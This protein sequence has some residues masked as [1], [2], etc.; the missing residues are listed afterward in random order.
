MAKEVECVNDDADNELQS[1]NTDMKT[2][3]AAWLAFVTANR[4]VDDNLV[5]IQCQHLCRVKYFS[6]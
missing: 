4:N 2:V 1:P 3:Q 6:R 5:C